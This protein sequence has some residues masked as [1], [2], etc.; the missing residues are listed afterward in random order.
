MSDTALAPEPWSVHLLGLISP[1]LAITGNVLGGAYTLSGVL[2]IWVLSPI[3]DVLFG[4]AESPRPPRDSG[5]PFERLL[6]VHG[7]L[8]FVMLATFFYFVASE[9]ITRWLLAASLSTGLVAAASAI[10]TAHELGH[11]R[12]KSPGWRLARALLFSINYTHFTTE[13]NHNHHKNVATEKDPASATYEQ[14]IWAFWV[15][16]IPGQFIS[17][18]RVHNRKGR[19][20]MR[21]PSWRGLALQLLCVLILTSLHYIGID[22]AAPIL[23]GWLIASG[24]AILTLEYVNYIRHWG[25]R[26]DDGG[27]FEE[28]HAWNTEARWSRWSL[29]ELT[30]HSDHHLHASVPFWKLR[31]YPDAPRLPSGYYACWWP[32]LFTPLWR[33]MMRGRAPNI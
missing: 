1:M 23:V 32:C 31:P 4:E 3:L 24:I 26:R 25:L 12:P 21:N 15:R 19:T 10:V 14:S 5:T 17:S 22:W 27:R 29:L 16:T 8:H 33:R 9:G 6:W 20:G 28:G 7:I 2:F 13:H 18:V 30:R 11:Q